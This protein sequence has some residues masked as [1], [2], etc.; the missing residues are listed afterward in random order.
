MGTSSRNA[1]HSADSVVPK[2]PLVSFDIINTNDR[3]IDSFEA[4]DLLFV[5]DSLSLFA[6][7]FRLRTRAMTV[8]NRGQ[9]PLLEVVFVR[10]RFALLVSRCARMAFPDAVQYKNWCGYPLIL[11]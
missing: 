6:D 4:G 7:T 3:R 5:V 11:S 9:R 8:S 2:V 10:D 1:T